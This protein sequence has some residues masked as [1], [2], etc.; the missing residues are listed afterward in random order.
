V[1]IRAFEM[2]PKTVEKLEKSPHNISII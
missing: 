2:E 1:F